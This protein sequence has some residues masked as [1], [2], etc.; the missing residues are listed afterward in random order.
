M[1]GQFQAVR[2]AE[3]GRGIVAATESRGWERDAD[4]APATQPAAE[5]SDRHPG[6]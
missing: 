6:G 1:F 4:E 3:R 5:T 2:N